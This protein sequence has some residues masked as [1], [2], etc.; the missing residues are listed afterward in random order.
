M[1]DEELGK[2]G[3][4]IITGLAERMFTLPPDLVKYLEPFRG[5]VSP[6]VSLGYGPDYVVLLSQISHNGMLT[7]RWQAPDGKLLWELAMR[8]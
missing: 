2:L 8:P 4:Q 3:E 5:Y 1:T 6:P 7:L